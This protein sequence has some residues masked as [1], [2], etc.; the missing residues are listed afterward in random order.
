MPPADQRELAGRRQFGGRPA[1]SFELGGHEELGARIDRAT[2]RLE[3]AQQGRRER[4]E[5]EA[6]R[7][8][9]ERRQVDAAAAARESRRDQRARAGS[10]LHALPAAVA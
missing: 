2:R 4:P 7:R 9:V 8:R 5:V 10:G 6:V 3:A 1:Q